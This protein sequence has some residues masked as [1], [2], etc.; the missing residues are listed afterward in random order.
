M[1]SDPNNQLD[2]WIDP[3]LIK[4]KDYYGGGLLRTAHDWMNAHTI[5]SRSERL[6]INSNDD[7]D[8]ID[9]MVTLNRSIAHRLSRLNATYKFRNIKHPKKPKGLLEQLEFFGLIKP[10]MLIQIAAIRNSIEHQF[11]KAPTKKRCQELL[12]FAWYF[13]RSTDNLLLS[14]LS[15]LVIEH[16]IGQYYI[17]LSIMV[18]PDDNWDSLYLGGHIPACFCSITEKLDWIHLKILQAG[19]IYPETILPA[20]V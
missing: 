7:E 19:E 14:P 13:L 9:G 18:G 6:I 4:G 5:W 12:D 17:H 15:N 16:S 2:I 20:Y 8:L 3:Q 1:D 10:V 11:K